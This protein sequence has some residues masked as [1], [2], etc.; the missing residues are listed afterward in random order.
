MQEVLLAV[1]LVRLI[2]MSQA[3][4]ISTL[5][6]NHPESVGTVGAFSSLGLVMKPDFLPW[7]RLKKIPVFW[8]GIDII[9]F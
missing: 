2:R 4:Q 7:L 9:D 5:R 6:S 1:A 3:E 8:T